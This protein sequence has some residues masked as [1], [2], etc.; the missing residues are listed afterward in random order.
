MANRLIQAALGAAALVAVAVPAARAGAQH[1]RGDDRTVKVMIVSMVASERQVWLDRL[2]PWRDIAVPGLSPHYPAVH[3]NRSGVCIV[4][5]GIGHSNAAASI[6]ALV[7]SRMF[8]LSNT[9]FIVAG[10]AGIDP[11]QGTLG[12]AAWARYLVEFGLQW[13]IDA[14]EIPPEWTS[15]YLGI[16]AANPTQKP[17]LESR[18]E[19]FQLNEALLGHAYALSRHVPLADSAPAQ[20]AR[21]KFTAAP[22]NRPPAVLQCD[23]ASADT[24]FSGTRLGQRASEWTKILTD[25]RGV[26]C[27]AQQ[28]D[29]ATYEALRRGATAKLVDLDRVAVLRAG[30]NFLRPYEGQSSADNLLSYAAQG[31]FAIALENLYRA[32][33][34]L[35]RQIV[36]DWTRWRR[37]V[38][39]D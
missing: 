7:F 38:P 23:T 2:G 24:W 12:S 6:T 27:T 11:A 14:R 33:S 34:P 3:C 20:A 32:A 30:S 31:G 39:V 21:A 36:D 28:E 18:T 10:V 8:D 25:G 35:V 26:F 17:R 1:A 29:N 5:T 15:G 22:A 16:Y 9:Y 13:E 37:G 19:V 4:T